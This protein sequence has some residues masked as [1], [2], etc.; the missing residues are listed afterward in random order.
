[1]SLQDENQKGHK[2]S[3]TAQHNHLDRMYPQIDVNLFKPQRLEP[4][5]PE[6]PMIMSKTNGKCFGTG[7]HRFSGET[8]LKESMVGPSLAL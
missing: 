2:V 7:S 5:L 4:K 8:K 6:G 1:M 3:K